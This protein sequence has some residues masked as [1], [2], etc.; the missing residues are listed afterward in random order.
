[1]TE[2]IDAHHH[3]WRYSKEGYG[4]IVPGME[5][6]ARDFLPQDLDAEVKFCGIDGT[7]AVQAKQTVAETE[8]LLDLA[9]H[10]SVIR[11]VVGWAPL[12]S[13]GLGAV[14]EKWSSRKK[15][16]GLRHVVQDEPDEAFLLRDDFNAGVSA[17]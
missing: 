5:A 15:L 7:I 6:L 13:G 14:L 10:S 1:M 9:E 16:K 8:W 12:C 11:G 3:L 17:L 2:R 4:W